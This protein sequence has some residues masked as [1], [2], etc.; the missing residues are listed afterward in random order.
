MIYL[1]LRNLAES[2]Q[3]FLSILGGSGKSRVVNFQTARLTV[4]PLSHRQPTSYCTE[5]EL[6]R[7]W[8]AMCLFWIDAEVR[9]CGIGEGRGDGSG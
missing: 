4:S 5:P 9:G 8:Q 1:A 2:C 7:R 3:E 6:G